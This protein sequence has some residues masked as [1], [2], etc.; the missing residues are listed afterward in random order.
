M[1]DNPQVLEW[2]GYGFYIEVPEGAL[3]P[4]VTASVRVRAILGGQFKLPENSQ[5]IS[6]LYWVSCSE[7]FLKEVAVN[8]E[9]CADVE[10]VKQ[11]SSFRFII[12]KICSQKAPCQE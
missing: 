9:H 8:I 11:S 10:N 6:A 12:A 4:G 7:E 5:L 3:P 2:S 1:G